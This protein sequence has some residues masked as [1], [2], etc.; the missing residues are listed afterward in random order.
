MN[1]TSSKKEMEES[2]NRLKSIKKVKAPEELYTKILAK[3]KKQNQI[4]LNWVAATAA[5]FSCLIISEIY[6][7]N[8]TSEANEIAMLELVVPQ[9]NN[10]LYNE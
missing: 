2:L 6:V 3:I 10:L 5:V 8:Y 1:K 4:S 7:I 9:T